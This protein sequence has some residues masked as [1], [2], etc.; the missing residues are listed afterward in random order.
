MTEHKQPW[1][2]LVSDAESGAVLI[3][4]RRAAILAAEAALKDLQARTRELD[5]MVR[6]AVAEFRARGMTM[7]AQKLIN[8]RGLAGNIKKDALEEALSCSAQNCSE[9][10]HIHDGDCSACPQG[11]IRARAGLA[12]KEER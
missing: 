9:F 8:W 3:P 2:E 11:T 6:W 12:A 5:G 4:K 1:D 10:G 7:E